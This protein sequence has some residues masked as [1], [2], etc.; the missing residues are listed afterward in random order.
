MLPTKA[1][2]DMFTN[3]HKQL[4]RIEDISKS[5]RAILNAIEGDLNREYEYTPAAHQERFIESARW[6]I[7]HNHFTL[8]SLVGHLVLQVTSDDINNAK[9]SY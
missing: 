1:T 6:L 5:I 9:G 7:G 4:T 2:T 8:V 3:S